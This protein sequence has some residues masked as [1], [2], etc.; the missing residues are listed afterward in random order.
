MGWRRYWQ[1]ITARP[2]RPDRRRRRI[3]CVGDSI[4][5]GAGVEKTRRQEAW[6]ALWQRSLGDGFQVLNY[7]VCSATLQREGDFAY[8]RFG[9]LPRM[10][11]ARPELIVLMLGTNDTKPRNWDEA[12]FARELEELVRELTELP[13]PHR[14]ALLA[15]P[16]AFPAEAT[17]VIAYEIDNARIRDVIRPLIFSVGERR[18]LPVVDLYALTEA[19]P[20]YFDDGVH[21]NAPGNRALAEEIR[22][23]VPV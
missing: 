5:Y 15:P 23:A 16:K 17:G 11:R 9:F 12:R 2:E 22:R 4:T 20:E 1:R 19:H 8:R 13:W 10:K 14:V 7:G 18:G 3:A 21:P 6:P